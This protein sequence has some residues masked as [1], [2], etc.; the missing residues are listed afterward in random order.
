MQT[1]KHSG[2]VPVAGLLWSL[3][4][5]G[6][7]A[8]LL[9]VVYAYATNYIPLVYINFLLTIGYGAAIG[10]A[11]GAGARM[12]RVRNLPVVVSGGV[13]M[14][15]VGLYVAWAFDPMARFGFSPVFD[16]LALYAYVQ[17]FYENGFWGM[18]GDNT[19]SGIFL[20]VVWAAEAGTILFLAGKIPAG[21]L[22]EKPFC[23]NCIQWGTTEGAVQRL[24]VTPEQQG[25]LN[26]LL[27]GDLQALA[28]FDRTPGDQGPYLT[29]DLTTC[30][31]CAES[32]F[33]TVSLVT[34]T[35]DREGKPTSVVQPLLQN[36]VVHESEIELIRNA[37]REPIP[38]APL[39][40]ADNAEEAVN[41]MT[42][43]GEKV[44]QG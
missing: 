10:G 16:P 2:R 5:G 26:R 39:E 43:S 1:Y 14:G 7:T 6:A 34:P 38:A 28:Q 12:G 32:N 37:G 17:V 8:A 15:L 19:V 24:S 3:M 27:T 18:S 21:V 22:A 11:V 31:S 25:S 44:Q 33:L 35:T 40:D 13:L 36:L 42:P 29:L 23:E 9:G 30:S 41:L 20:G 4:V